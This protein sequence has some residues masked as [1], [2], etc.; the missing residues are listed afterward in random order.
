VSTIRNTSEDWQQD[1]VQQYFTI[2][3]GLGAGGSDALTDYVTAQERGGQSQLV[4]SD[5]LPT[6]TGGTDDDFVALG[7][8]FGDPD[9]RDPMFRAATL[10]LGWSRAATDHAMQS[11]LIDDLG[12]ERVS[13]F[14]KAAFYDRRADMRLV[15]HYGYLS[16]CLYEDRKPIL[17]DEWLTL[18]GAREELE[19][20]A[21]KSEERAA[22][23][24]NLHRRDNGN[25]Y[26]RE[27]AANYRAEAAKARA[28]SESLS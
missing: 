1:P 27:S 17:D 12:R 6:D 2:A 21:A 22:E 5:R 13:I 15:S 18:A 24:D 26:W 14:Y 8:T 16:S 9:P 25:D 23:A 3:A 28:L 10:P 4:N 20:M 7:F 19:R 11:K